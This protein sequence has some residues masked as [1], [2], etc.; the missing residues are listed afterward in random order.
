METLV[1]Y[2]NPRQLQ[3]CCMLRPHNGHELIYDCPQPIPMILTLNINYT[4]V[5]DIVVPDHLITHPSLPIAAYR[6]GFG[7]WCSRIVAPTG[8]VRLSTNAIVNDTGE[9]TWSPPRP[10]RSRCKICPRKHWCSCWAADIAKRIGC[11]RRLGISSAIRLPVE[12]FADR[13]M[14]GAEHP[15]DAQCPVSR[16]QQPVA[17]HRHTGAE[18]RGRLGLSSGR[19]QSMARLE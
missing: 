10:N 3:L 4:Q 13:P 12:H 15:L 1:G 9:P 14:V 16:C 5:S 2:F 7:N 8:Q 18:F 19:S 11:R 17:R 6:D